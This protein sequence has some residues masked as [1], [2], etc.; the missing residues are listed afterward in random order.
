MSESHFHKLV[1]EGESN[2]LDQLIVARIPSLTRAVVQR[3]I[4]E[5]RVRVNGKPV[6]KASSRPVRGD[7]VELEVPAPKVLDHLVPQSIPLDILHEDADLIVLNKAPGMVVHPAPGHASGTLVNALMAR[8]GAL[9][10]IGGAL[11]PGIVHRLDKE[12]SGAMVVA[13]ND[14]THLALKAQFQAH[15]VK[16]IYEALLFGR[17]KWQTL[18][19][20]T[21]LARDPHDRKRVAS[22]SFGRAAISIFHSLAQYE[23]L[24]RAQIELKTGRTHQ[25]RV[26]AAE[27]HH[28]VVGDAL[29]GHTAALARQLKPSVRAT[30]EGIEGQALHCRIL[31]FTH[32]TTE[33]WVEF[34]AAF[35]P[36]LALALERLA[37]LGQG[38]KK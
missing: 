2:R 8:P 17:P 3:L 5:G 25:I 26:H 33:K 30:L 22:R 18:R 20:D 31:G 1:V 37:A 23:G 36:G 7:Q 34:E 11:R 14:K 19:V 35:P 24:C 4:E 6:R 13:C 32:P 10:V 9:S 12:T 16:K 28:P 29:Y 15:T 27:M 38:A 21:K